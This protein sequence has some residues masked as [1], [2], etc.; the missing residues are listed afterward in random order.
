[1]PGGSTI[2]ELKA[3]MEQMP[4]EGFKRL[5][6]KFGFNYG[7]KFS[8]IK[9]IWH[10]D[11]EGFCLIDISESPTIQNESSAYVLHPCIIDACLQSCFVALGELEGDYTSIVPVGF[12]SVTLNHVPST[13][14]L[15]CHAIETKFGSFDVRLM[16]PCGRVLLT[17]GD[18]RLAGVTSTERE[19]LFE[20]LR[21]EV[22]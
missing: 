6:E 5:T 20:E 11:N 15:Y 21:Y 13:N 3:D 4:V 9:Q 18:F 1:M 8:L 22:Q 16:S 10:R 7:S 17:M 19:Y 14:Q 12:K 2:N